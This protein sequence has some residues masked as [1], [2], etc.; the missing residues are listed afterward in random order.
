MKKVII[1]LCCLFS[2]INLYSQEMDTTSQEGFSFPL[3]C[4]V[5]IKLVPIDSVNFHYSVLKFEEFNEIID[6]YNND[7]LLSKNVEENIIEFIFCIG[8][9]GDTEEEKEKH[10]KT[11][12]LLK[13]GAKIHLDYEADALFYQQEEYQSTSV[14]TLW[15]QAKIVE[16]WKD[17]I[18][19]I[20]IY[21]FHKKETN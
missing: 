12:L 9:H 14:V 4:K 10:Y 3:G 5:T 16:M 15:S 19:F 1:I 21:N 17:A 7:S 8:T 20:A 6:T 11:L 13:S 18:E 2:G